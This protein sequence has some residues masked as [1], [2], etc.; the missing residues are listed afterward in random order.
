MNK[1]ASLGKRNK[2]RACRVGSVFEQF[3][4]EVAGRSAIIEGG[5]RKGGLPGR[6]SLSSR[7]A[8]GRVTTFVEGRRKT[9]WLSA[10]QTVPTEESGDGGW[11]RPS[12][13]SIMVMWR[14]NRD[15]G[16]L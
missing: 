7:A 1:G 5:G 8:G 12:R 16:S 6:M 2:K 14:G 3:I 9:H 4:G 15:M 13:T 11:P 10:R